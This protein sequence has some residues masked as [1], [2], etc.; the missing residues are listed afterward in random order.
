MYLNLNQTRRDICSLF[1]KIEFEEFRLKM[2]GNI[3]NGIDKIVLFTLDRR[4]LSAKEANRRVR[5]ILRVEKERERGR[6]RSR[7]RQTD[8]EKRRGREK[9][10][11]NELLS[12]AS[13]ATHT[14]I[15]SC[16]S[17]FSL[18]ATWPPFSMYPL[19]LQV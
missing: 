9:E 16:S 7:D 6:V 5:N 8:G 1:V 18:R 12:D 17:S 4:K 15:C 19:P 14:N 3:F 2:A 13:A 10:N 11:I